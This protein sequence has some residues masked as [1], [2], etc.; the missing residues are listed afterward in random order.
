[1]SQ[2]N[3]LHQFLGHH[4]KTFAMH[5]WSAT[6]AQYGFQCSEPAALPSMLANEENSMQRQNLCL[7]L[8]QT[9]AY[10]D[11]A[12]AKHQNRIDVHI[13]RHHHV[14]W[15]AIRRE[16]GMCMAR[17]SSKQK[18]LLQPMRMLS[19]ATQQKPRLVPHIASHQKMTAMWNASQYHWKQ[20]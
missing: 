1:M 6:P 13:M 5:S 8:Q 10:S 7:I 9:T 20:R 19:A 17:W 11:L 18:K 12:L 2:H 3:L 16:C 14:P 4:R 15:S